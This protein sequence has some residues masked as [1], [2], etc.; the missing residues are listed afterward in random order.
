MRDDL[1]GLPRAVQRAA[2]RNERILFAAYAIALGLALL[3][4]FL[5]VG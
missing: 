2:R 4:L 5:A 3:A 1:E